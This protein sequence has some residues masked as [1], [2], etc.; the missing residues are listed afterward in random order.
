MSSS[1][2]ESLPV[3]DDEKEEAEVID[4]QAPYD[5]TVIALTSDEAFAELSDSPW[6]KFLC[7]VCGIVRR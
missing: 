4:L 5:A 1:S 3:V 6:S 2:Y 7:S